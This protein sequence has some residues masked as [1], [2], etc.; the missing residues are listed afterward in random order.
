M[1]YMKDEKIRPHHIES[2]M[3]SKLKVMEGDIQAHNDGAD[4]R[5]KIDRV[6][7]TKTLRENIG[8]VLEFDKECE[9][10]GHKLSSRYSVLVTL[11]CLCQFARNKPFEQFTKA[12]VIAF[13]EAAK[14]RRFQDTRSRART[15]NVERQL[16][17]STMNLVRLRVK[18]FFQRLHNMENGQYPR[19][20]RWLKL[21][22]IRGDKEL[23]PED[24]P[25]THE[26]KQM[27]ECTE[28]PRD[29]ALISLLAE[30][31]GRAGEIS[32]IR[33]RDISWNDKG[34]VLTLAGKTAQRQIP[35]CACAADLKTW[36]NNFHPFKNDPEAPLFTSFTD[37]RTPKTNLKADGIG[38]VV[39][40]AAIRAGV[41]KRIRMHPHKFRHLRASQLAEAGWNEPM[42]RQYF[43][44]A[45][46]SKMPATYIHMTQKSM[47]NRYY[48]MYGKADA[49]E[50]KPQILEEPKLCSAC[51]TQN[52]N[53]YRFCFQCDAALDEEEQ[54]RVD[55]KKEIQNTLNFIATDTELTKKFSRLLKEAVEKQ[56]NER[57]VPTSGSTAA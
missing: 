55:V 42:L 28:N 54:K 49:E 14:H 23:R 11:H 39:R 25:T 16:A 44:W 48:R 46:A 35:L 45:K 29:R 40:R 6:K 1:P 9:Q 57:V 27:V 17:N 8:K 37:L 32:T 56:K 31:G 53:G 12:D 5:S 47:N 2:T 33:L 43:G 24:L 10:N 3:E 21:R 13:L 52:P 36:I 18:R 7:Q 50:Q 38:T 20:V 34:F 4:L 41:E 15:G 51:G 22:T 30:S 26:A 19:C